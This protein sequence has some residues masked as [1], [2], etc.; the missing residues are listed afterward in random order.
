MYGR[1]NAMNALFLSGE[2]LY[3]KTWIEQVM[4]ELGPVFDKIVL[5]D[6]RHWEQGGT[7]DFA[8]ELSRVIEEVNNL[9]PYAIFAKSAGAVLSMLG[10]AR[11]A[12]DPE[13]CVFVGVPLPLAKRTEDAFATWARNYHKS[14]LFIQNDQDPLTNAHE[15]NAYLLGIGQQNYELIT[16]PGDSHNYPDMAKLHQLVQ[17]HIH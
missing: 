13:Y 11:G 3:N 1:Q 5:H 7:I 6:Y 14:T 4:D 15:L 9:Q 10:I 2:S 12:L 16:L 8:Y 17:T